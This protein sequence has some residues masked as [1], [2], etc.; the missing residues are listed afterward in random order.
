VILQ[1]PNWNAWAAG[2]TSFL[3]L[4]YLDQVAVGISSATIYA[5]FDFET[6]SAAGYVWNGVQWESLPGLSASNRGIKAVG[7]RN[8]VQDASF[9]PLCLAYD[10]KDGR[11]RRR[12]RSAAGSFSGLADSPPQDL[13]DYI[14]RGGIIEAWNVM[15]EW[16]VWEFYCV[17]VFGWPS[18]RL[19]QLRCCMAK[20]RASGYP[21]GLDDAAKVLKLV[22]RKDP[23]GDRLIRKLTVPKKPTK[24]NQ[25]LQ[26]TPFTANEDFQKLYAYNEQDI[27]TE[28]EASTRIPDLTPRELEVWRFDFRCNA[29][30]MQV[31]LYDIEN[32]IAIVEQAY[33]K[34]NA[35][36]RERT[37]GAVENSTEVAKM[38]KWMAAQGVHLH[39]LDE[40]TVTE[41]L[42]RSYPPAVLRALRIRQLLAFGSVRKL[43][44]FRSHSTPLG[45]LHDQYIFCGAHTK[46]WN[47]RAVQPANLYKGAFSNPDQ[48]EL[49]LQLIATR[50]LATVEAAY[51]DA[52]EA[53]A[54]CLRSMIVAKPGHKLISADFTAIQA[55]ATAALAGEEWQLD[56]F[57]T[58]GMIYEATASQLTGKPLQFY[59]DYRAQHKKHHEDRQ[60][61]GKIPTL[62]S[63]FGAWIGGWKRFGAD[64]LGDDAFIKSL[65]LK[66]RDR[67]PNTV[68]LWG[69]QTRDKFRHGERPELYGLEGAAISAVLS[70]GEC[71]GYRGIAFQMYED[72]LYCQPPSGGFLQ[73]HAPRLET[74]RRDYACPW[75]LELTYEGWNSNATKGRPG[76]Q[77]M[78][79]YGGVLTQN[80]VAF[81][82]REIQA[83]ALLAL[84][85]HE[86]RPYPIVMHT[87]DEQ[88]AEVPDRPEFSTAEYTSI[89]RGS[90]ADWARTPDGRPWP[91]K[92]PEAW[93]AYRYGKWE[94]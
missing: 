79:L 89:V 9:T 28:A 18:L 86:P 58:H 30:G 77:R 62:A 63:G 11:G 84:D 65:I 20:S 6:F 3:D 37:H 40:E 36:L 48:V 14:A 53:V 22:N 91:I 43:Y 10:L 2:Q 29:R 88:V 41:A 78:K 27:A 74:S 80:T 87:H 57:R 93:E 13:L 24:G 73:Y 5:E 90:L 59:I 47:A 39:E 61:F 94:D 55:V 17:P 82:S 33:E 26:W 56:V 49:A 45:R 35:E 16:T 60:G 71:F 34:Y 83:D 25:Q 64:K 31:S 50:N 51:G 52:L 8:Y 67:I 81:V 92:V 69:G 54:N 12:W 1:T 7:S 32:C 44:A 68:E 70:P 42:T 38:L 19:E 21:G 4:R 15:F 72:T 85:T 46:L 66:T 76:W 23:D 75:E